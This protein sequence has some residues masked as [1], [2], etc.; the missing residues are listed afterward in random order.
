PAALYEDQGHHFASEAAAQQLLG[1]IF[2]DLVGIAGIEMHRRILGLAHVAEL[3]TIEDEDLRAKCETKC[4]KLGQL[5]VM[6]RN[7]LTGMD[8]VIAAARHTESGAMA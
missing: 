3:D 7:R 8:A 1:E 6:S 5:L 4:L 2:R